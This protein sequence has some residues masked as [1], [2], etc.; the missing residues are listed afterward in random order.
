MVNPDRWACLNKLAPIAQVLHHRIRQDRQEIGRPPAAAL[1]PKRV[2]RQLKP[3]R[4]VVTVWCQ[5][6]IDLA[7]VRWPTRPLQVITPADHHAND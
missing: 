1:V 3:G 2:V 6:G 5:D 7:P 4:F